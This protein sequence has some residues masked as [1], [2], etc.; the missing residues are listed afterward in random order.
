MFKTISKFAS[1]SNK[2][3]ALAQL[4]R[5]KRSKL[6][7]EQQTRFSSSFLMLYSV[8]VAY[9]RKVFDSEYNA[10]FPFEIEVVENYIQIL[11]PLYAFSADLQSNKAH[12]GLVV[13]ALLALLYENLDR[14]DLKDENQDQFRN[15]LIHFLQIK[16]N[17]ELS[18]KEY[19]VAAVL[20]VGYLTHWSKR[21][22]GEKPFQLGIE[23]IY[24]LLMKYSANA[25]EFE[26]A[27]GRL[28]HTDKVVSNA[29]QK[30]TSE[31]LNSL[32]NMTRPRANSET[33]DLNKQTKS[34]ILSD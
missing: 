31:G 23:S 24:E 14:M 2:V 12:I 10:E 30:G 34:K 28:T 3:I 7:K 9:K 15:D 17:F 33:D 4:H 16:F 25:S 18:S 11:L 29:S 21:S 1:Q 6:Q 8:L 22:F 27:H 19:H 13:P 5:E 20:N 26:K 32:R